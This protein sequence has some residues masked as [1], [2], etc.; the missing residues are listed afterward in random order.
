MFLQCVV[1]QLRAALSVLSKKCL[2]SCRRQATAKSDPT[3][4]LCSASS[5]TFCEH[6]LLSPPVPMQVMTVE[7]RSFTRR[8]SSKDQ[9]VL[10]K[11]CPHASA[12]VSSSYA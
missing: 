10:Q 4:S 12:G 7:G 2:A 11:R 8:A 9:Q 5:L 3:L 6:F 1:R